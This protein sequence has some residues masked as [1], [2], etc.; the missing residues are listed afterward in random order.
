MADRLTGMEVF[1]RAVELGSLAEAARASR[2]SA[3]MVGK[4]LRALE[5]RI[6]IRL[7]NRTTR[8][9]GLTETGRTYY[10]RC[11]QILAEISDAEREAIEQQRAP[12]GLIRV[13][14]PVAFGGV[15]LARA[16][17]DFN[18]QYDE[19]SVEAVLNN[20]LVDLMD[21]GCDLAI[22]IA[23]LP[24][25]DLIARRLAPC[26][27]VV[28][29]AP[30]YLERYGVPER[31]ED[32][33]H[34]NCLI[35]LPDTDS[36]TWRFKGARRE[37]AISIKGRVQGNSGTL[38]HEIALAGGGIVRLPSFIVGED[39]KGGRLVPLLAD[40]MCEELGIYAVFLD[41]RPLSARVRLFVEFLARRFGP[42]PSWDDWMP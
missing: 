40:H 35:H 16:I 31:P 34:H 5:A 22:R 18:A 38:L 32:L 12:R 11:R 10:D 42:E 33:K 8:R 28:C 15:H 26:R 27:R 23:R 17:T 29:A 9:L 24:D 1:V 19:V 13:N 7:L 37:Q 36:A 25:S 41:A 39:L 20:N 30:A 4:H 21:G 14:A 2:L 6:G 3:G